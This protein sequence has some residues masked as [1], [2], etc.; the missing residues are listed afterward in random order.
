ML[1]GPQEP[2]RQVGA[3]AGNP[4]KARLLKPLSAVDQDGRLMRQVGETWNHILD[5]LVAVAAA[6]AVDM[7]GSVVPGF[8]D[9]YPAGPPR[10]A[11]GR[12]SE[13]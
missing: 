9:Y 4:L 10:P 11:P 2:M 3:R 8:R 13:W 6:K 7:V 5:A 1:L 12:P